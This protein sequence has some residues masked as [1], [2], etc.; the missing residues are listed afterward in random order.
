METVLVQINNNKAY[1]L[2]EDLEDLDII[3]VL[4][5]DIGINEHLV[6]NKKPSDYFGTL[7][8][9]E[10]KKMQTYVIQGRKEWERSI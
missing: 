7:T 3:K 8:E 6:G 2:L 1:K 9:E 4:S 5:R 10:G